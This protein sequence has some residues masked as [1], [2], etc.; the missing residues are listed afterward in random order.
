MSIWLALQK[1]VPQ[2]GLSRWMGRLAASERSALSAFL[3]RLFMRIYAVDLA[4]AERRSIADYVSFNDFFTRALAA[5]A[6][7][8][9]F[10]PEIAVSPADGTVSQT[11]AIAGDTMVQAKGVA[12]SAATLLGDAD[13]AARFAG[14]TFATVYLAPA[15]YHRVHAPCEGALRRS[16]AI[17]G[18]LFSVND[19]T[20]SGIA[21]LF[22]RNE[23]LVLEFDTRFGPLAVVLVGALVVASIE[24]PFGTPR[25]P[26][27][28]LTETRHDRAVAR[29]EEIGR[30]VVGS[31]V[32]VVFPPGACALDARIR[33]G[34]RIRMGE[35][36]GAIR[37]DRAETA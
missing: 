5:G 35:P 34:Q 6:R 14:G 37:R 26:Y 29:G 32:I 7:P 11:G 24:T 22:C 19:H 17:P 2:H 1:A 10:D 23:R 13:L 21:G 3:I 36:L 12:Y 28:R 27:R 18:A 4:E 25:S 33:A 30:F 20:E 16:I 8:M 31:T 15:D 9:S